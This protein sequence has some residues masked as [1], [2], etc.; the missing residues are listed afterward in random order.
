M[1]R[2]PDTF[3]RHDTELLEC[4]VVYRLCRTAFSVGRL[5]LY[6]TKGL[7]GVCGGGSSR[8]LYPDYLLTVGLRYSRK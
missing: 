3:Q 8:C 5:L 1:I 2:E 4:V 7:A 6:V